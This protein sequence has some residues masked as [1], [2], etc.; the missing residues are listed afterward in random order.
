MI[1]L[2]ASMVLVALPAAP[3]QAA[4][5]NPLYADLDGPLVVTTGSVNMYVLSM[6]GGPAETWTGN[7]SYQATL[8]GDGDTTGATFLPSSAGPKT[9][10]T[11]YINLT[12]PSEPQ[13]L[14][15]SI[16]CTSAT[17]NYTA[18]ETV[19]FQVEV[20]EPVVLSSTIENTGDVAVTGVPLSLQIYEDGLWVEFYNTTL[21]LAAGESYDFQYNWTALG[22][23]SGEHKVRMLLD[24]NNEIVTFEGGASV[25]ETTIYYNASGYGWVNSLLWV[26][27]I[28]IG[29]TIY[30]VWRRPTKGKGKKRR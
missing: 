7:Y 28:V 16:V 23:T 30:F 14:T 11:F 19:Q 18:T 15:M 29:V 10:S 24:P 17:L 25:Y 26:L 4:S 5:Y 8:T 20:V 9:A 22:L 6:I 12:A 13:R 3:S 2:V 1:L 27:V 21:D